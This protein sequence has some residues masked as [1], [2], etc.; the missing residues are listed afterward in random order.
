MSKIL[1]AEAKSYEDMVSA[2]LQ[3]AYRQS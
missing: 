1:P 3:A 2:A